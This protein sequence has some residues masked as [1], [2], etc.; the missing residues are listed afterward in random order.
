MGQGFGTSTLVELD[1]ATGTLVS[2]IGDVG[3]LVNGM[4]WDASSGTLWAT[5][6][7]DDAT[8]PSGMITIDPMTGVG[9]P[10][11]AGAGLGVRPE[12]AASNSAGRSTGGRGQRRCLVLFDTSAGTILVLGDAGLSTG[13]LGLAFDPADVLFLVNFDG[14]Y[15]IDTATGA[16]TFIGGI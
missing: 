7:A 4:T 15:T 13:P 3:Y 1:P 10:V 6:S 8:F 16:A 5:T 14:V 9:T 11:G 2:T 12:R